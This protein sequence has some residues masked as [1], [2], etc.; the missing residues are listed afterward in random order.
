MTPQSPDA[1]SFSQKLCHWVIAALFVVQ[2]PL[3]FTTTLVMDI[4]GSDLPI[5]AL[6]HAVIGITIMILGIF[7]LFS[8]RRYREES[9]SIPFPLWQYR[10]A[11]MVQS[12][13]LFSLAAIPMT[14]G[15]CLIGFTAMEGRH[16]MMAIIGI[17]LVGIHGTAA[18][19]HH[20][21]MRDNTL[22]RMLPGR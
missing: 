11:K 20:F 6:L 15:A 19:F 4:S 14:G 8:V 2:I 9:S 3:G 18:L 17:L 13:L 5:I 7:F 10:L 1:Y 12:L 22:R 16:R 21:V